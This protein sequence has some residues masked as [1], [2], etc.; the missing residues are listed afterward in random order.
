M[1]QR[2]S[3]KTFKECHAGAQRWRILPFLQPPSTSCLSFTVP[4]CTTP[5]PAITANFISVAR[6]LGDAWRDTC[7]RLYWKDVAYTE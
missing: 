6:Q 5:I 7:V 2:Y 4:R 3:R 1:T